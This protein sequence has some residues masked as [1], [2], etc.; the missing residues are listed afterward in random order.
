MK[1]AAELSDLSREH[2]HGLVHAHR[3]QKAALDDKSNPVEYT[4]KASL[5][6]WHAEIS[7]QL[8]IYELPGR[9]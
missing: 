1:R 5:K 8:R 7:I 9:P 6:F 4:A 2:H 3:L